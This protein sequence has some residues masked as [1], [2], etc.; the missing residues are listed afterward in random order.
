M[1]GVLA[2]SNQLNSKN[3]YK[4]AATSPKNETAW[5]HVPP[6]LTTSNFKSRFSTY[7]EGPEYG[8]GLRQMEP[9]RTSPDGLSFLMNDAVIS[10][11]SRVDSWNKN[12]AITA[13]HVDLGDPITTYSLGPGGL[14]HDHV[15][16]IQLAETGYKNRAHRF[17]DP[18]YEID[19]RP[20]QINAF[21]KGKGD[22]WLSGAGEDAL[23]Q[24]VREDVKTRHIEGRGAIRIEAIDPPTL[25]N[26][27]A[28]ELSEGKIYDLGMRIPIK[29]LDI[30][31][32]LY[33]KFFDKY[34]N[35]ESHQ[36]V[37]ENDKVSYP[38]DSCFKINTSPFGEL[39]VTASQDISNTDLQGMRNQIKKHL[40]GKNRNMETIV[41]A[42]YNSAIE[43]AQSEHK[44]LSVRIQ[45][46]YP[47]T[48]EKLK[49][50]IE[51]EWDGTTIFSG[52][53]KNK[54]D[55][56]LLKVQAKTAERTSDHLPTSV[57][58]AELPSPIQGR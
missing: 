40:E 43:K 44:R 32:T 18:S 55:V 42:S 36:Y 9:C 16:D 14:L 51:K 49:H 39:Q 27:P 6:K 53:E 37:F 20:E 58:A 15:E 19:G 22:V 50:C 12:L 8:G 45:A 30:G 31:N 33:I 41:L 35:T 24:K 29:Q 21:I 38:C 34:A 2:E 10:F 56:R 5:P 57:V 26:I 11:E 25:L 47:A 17:Y 46:N 54:V 3:E 4:A 13:N 48:L 52:I 23:C 7:C 1:S 28:K